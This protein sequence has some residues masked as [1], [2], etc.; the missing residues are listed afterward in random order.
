MLKF[1][2]YY[3]VWN[4]ERTDPIESPNKFSLLLHTKPRKTSASNRAIAFFITAPA[5]LSHKVFAIPVQNVLGKGL[6]LIHTGKLSSVSEM[7][8]STNHT[9]ILC[10]LFRQ[11]EQLI[12]QQ[13]HEH[14]FWVIVAHSVICKRIASVISTRSWWES[15]A[16]AQCQHHPPFL[17][18]VNAEQTALVCQICS[19]SLVPTLVVWKVIW[20]IY[21][22]YSQLFEEAQTKRRESIINSCPCCLQ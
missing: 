13:P 19:A 12:L 5:H 22:L 18:K 17:D 7:T 3:S 20:S 14:S 21:Q 15:P 2:L 8:L 4:K 10:N 16:H 9:L 11:G 1:P 6:Q